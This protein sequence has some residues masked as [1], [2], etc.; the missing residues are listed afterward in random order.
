M[1]SRRK[2][3]TSTGKKRTSKPSAAVPSK[4]PRTSNKGKNVIQVT[5]MIPINLEP[6][7]DKD[8]SPL[9]KISERKISDRDMITETKNKLMDMIGKARC[10]IK[11]SRE[12]MF[13]TFKVKINHKK[14][15]LTYCG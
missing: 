7:Y 14:P 5:E 3:P 15:L 12:K 2:G 8:S 4:R 11:V 6:K 9:E 13:Q 10:S 1:P